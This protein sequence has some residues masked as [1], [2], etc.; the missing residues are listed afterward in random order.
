MIYTFL[1]CI[2][3]CVSSFKISNTIDDLMLKIAFI[4]ALMLFFIEMI[5]FLEQG[6]LYFKG[7]NIIDSSQLA[8]YTFMCSLRILGFDNQLLFYP[9]LKLVNITLAFMKLLFFIRIYEQFGF[10]V[11]MIFSCVMALQNFIISYIV[12]LLVISVCYVVLQMEVDADVDEA[13]G[14]SYFEKIVL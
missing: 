13:Q 12:F 11:S 7:W 3:M 14:L 6:L 8:V 10:L 2:P 1:Y 9:E 4:P 5:Q